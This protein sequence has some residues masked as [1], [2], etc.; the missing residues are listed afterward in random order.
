MTSK[1]ILSYLVFLTLFCAPLYVIRTTIFMIPITLLEIMIGVTFLV[2]MIDQL[3]SREYFCLQHL[4]LSQ[5]L[6]LLTF[7]T[8][9]VLSVVIASDRMSA[10]GIFKAYILEPVLFFVVL[11]SVVKQDKNNKEGIFWSLIASGLLTSVI[12][13][14]QKVTGLSAWSSGEIAQGRVTGLF[15]SANALCLFLIPLTILVFARIITLVK[16]F[17]IRKELT[18]LRTYAFLGLTLLV[19]LLVIFWTQSSGGMM[20]TLFSLIFVAG[21]HLVPKSF[22]T[23][24]SRNKNIEWPRIIMVMIGLY[25]VSQLLFFTYV[26]RMTPKLEVR[27]LVRQ[28]QNTLTVRLCLWEG[29]WEMLKN[30]PLFGYGLSNFPENYR[31]FVTCD[32]ELLQYPHNFLLTIW[33]ELGLVG[34]LFFLWQIRS[35]IIS[36]LR[37]FTIHRD[38]DYWKIAL[39]AIFFYYLLHGLVDVPYFK[40]D[41][42]FLWWVFVGL[43]WI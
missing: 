23:I 5:R 27:P 26:N 11:V 9:G 43:S 16:S 3:V 22:L 1:K 33:S 30:R 20:G 19:F 24:I 38:T 35:V 25:V 6:S 7:L 10:L 41:L 8:I 28:F 32:P 37:K 39:L 15:N 13:I 2:W 12:A 4:T 29:S 42:S 21:L 40:N 31:S 18:V 34:M 14:A 17:S 36:N